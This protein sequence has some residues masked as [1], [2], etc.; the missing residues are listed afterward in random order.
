MT[1]R[2]GA[3]DAAR[4]SGR[5]AQRVNTVCIVGVG[6]I[7]GSFALALR[8][9]GFSGKIIGVSSPQTIRAALERRAVD[10]ALPLD[11][12]AAQSDVIFLA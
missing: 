8:K 1:V 7:G 12:A 5:R 4:P 10:V 2:D 6:L 11:Q 3:A 9:A